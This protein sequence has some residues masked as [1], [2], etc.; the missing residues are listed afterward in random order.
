MMEFRVIFFGCIIL[1]E[2]IP[3]CGAY[4]KDYPIQRWLTSMF[5]EYWIAGFGPLP[6][7]EFPQKKLE[8]VDILSD[9]RTTQY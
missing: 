5:L 1:I 6:C 2:A 8:F 9:M 4:L 3:A 7:L